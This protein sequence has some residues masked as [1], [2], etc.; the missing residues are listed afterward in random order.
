MK[1]EVSVILAGVCL[2]CRTFFPWARLLERP[3]FLQSGV[4]AKAV[5]QRRPAQ[6]VHTKRAAPD[7]RADGG[8]LASHIPKAEASV[9]SRKGDFV[10]P[11]TTTAQDLPIDACMP[12]AAAVR[13]WR[14]YSEFHAACRL[15]PNC[16]GRRA[17]VWQ[18]TDS[19]KVCGGL[20]DQL[21]GL[22]S[23]LYFAMRLGRPFL[24]D[25]NKFG[26]DWLGVF[27]H[28]RIDTA[29]PGDLSLHAC[30]T[31]F[32][33]NGGAAQYVKAMNEV[34]HNPDTCFVWRTNLIAPPS[35]IG[36]EDL[37]GIQN[38]HGLGCAF[39]FAFMLPH[40]SEN[41]R[42]YLGGLQSPFA[43]IHVRLGDDFFSSRP[44]RRSVGVSVASSALACARKHNFTR[45]LFVCV[46]HNLTQA[47]GRIAREQ[48][49]VLFSASGKPLHVDFLKRKVSRSDVQRGILAE[50]LAIARAGLVIGLGRP[51]G[52]AASAAS[53]ALLASD[54]VLFGCTPG[55][56][57]SSYWQTDYTEG[58]VP[59]R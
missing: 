13:V 41:D 5:T 35:S 34:A 23:T 36:P 31:R 19:V 24:T 51:S 12:T 21:R 44:G 49:M 58:M 25:W 48:N 9:H 55:R 26:I 30:R 47:A 52:Y 45:V 59:K 43:A 42:A 29:I 11:A 15:D 7:V 1:S 33:R 54:K 39:R 4:R 57:S 18:C 50:W 14:R 6:G 56:L 3:V 10:V 16:I 17:L 27:K 2:C 46:D 28:N 38:A 8:H 22:A 53:V 32:T 20:G 40:V 37:A